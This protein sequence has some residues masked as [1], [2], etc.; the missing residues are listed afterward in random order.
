MNNTVNDDIDHSNK[1]DEDDNHIVQDARCPLVRLLV[2]VHPSD[3][4]KEDA[5]NQLDQIS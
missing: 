4:E 2:D 1:G 5:A 3:Y